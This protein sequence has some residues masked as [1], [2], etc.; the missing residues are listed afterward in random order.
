MTRKDAAGSSRRK[1]TK[2]AVTRSRSTTSSTTARAAPTPPVDPDITG[3]VT[4]LRLLTD[5][6]QQ[7]VWSYLVK[8]ASP[9]L[10]CR[11]LGLSLRRFWTTLDHDPQFAI[12][13]DHLF[14]TLSHNVLAALYQRAMKGDKTA[15]QY[16]LRTMPP[17][18]GSSAAPTES[19]DDLTGL[20]D[21]ELFDRA[22]ATGVALPDAIAASL[23]S[24]SSVPSPGGIPG[25]IADDD[26]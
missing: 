8:G 5:D 22:N 20:T 7:Q 23:L 3:S 16:W 13:M 4:D 15:Q 12:A 1:P 17:F 14:R 6:E 2:K 24:T 18:T 11:E 26:G 10:A 19:D 21:A 25:G 9:Q